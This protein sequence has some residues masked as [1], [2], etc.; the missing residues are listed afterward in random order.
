VPL[1]AQEIC[2]QSDCKKSWFR[3]SPIKQKSHRQKYID[4][5]SR[6][7]K[8]AVILRDGYRCKHC[9]RPPS[10]WLPV[11][12]AH[13]Y[14]KGKYPAMRFLLDNVLL[15][16]R[17][18]HDWYDGKAPDSDFNKLA[19]WI[20]HILPKERRRLHIM[21]K[22]RTAA[23][24]ALPLSRCCW[25]ETWTQ[26]ACRID[27]AA[28]P[29]NVWRRNGGPCKH[30]WTEDCLPR[31]AVTGAI[32]ASFGVPRQRRHVPAV[33]QRL[34]GGTGPSQ[35]GRLARRQ[36]RG[37]RDGPGRVARWLCRSRPWPAR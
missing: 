34:R 26:K 23:W 31:R 6:L 11:D 10:A 30:Q 35:P 1:Q 21:A 12:C 5:L 24:C 15:L 7:L 32:P 37:S 13:I 19:E 36:R 29:T 2:H 28:Q 25:E 16:C 18:C 4:Y 8:R 14:P 9:R 33:R 3:K 22:A 20:Q 27:A 17:D